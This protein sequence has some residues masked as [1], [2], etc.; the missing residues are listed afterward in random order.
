MTYKSLD[1]IPYKL[2]VRI[3]ETEELELLSNEKLPYEELKSIWNKMYQEH[4]DKNQ[5]SDSK[6][7]QQIHESIEGLH[8]KY[9]WVLSA[10]ESLRFSLDTELVIMLQYLGFALRTRSTEEYYSDLDSIVLNAE[11]YIQ[12]AEKQ[13][14]M[15]PQHDEEESY[16]VDDVMASYCTILGYNIGKFNEIT[17]S[18][19]YA[20]DRSVKEKIKSFKKD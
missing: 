12:T 2:F 5:T 11:G 17:Y 9:K 14:T 16:T 20:F 19:Y 7:I 18:E 6:K 13:K 15:L 3:A 8:R 10:C 4:L 1:E